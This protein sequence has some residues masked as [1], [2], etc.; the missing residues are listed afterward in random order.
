MSVFT[1]WERFTGGPLGVYSVVAGKVAELKG[2]YQDRN[3]VCEGFR[4]KYGWAVKRG[5]LRILNKLLFT[6][7]HGRCTMNSKQKRIGLT[8]LCGLTLLGGG[9]NNA[10]QGAFSGAAL[11]SLAGMGLGSLSGN[12]GEG[13]A[14]GAIVG[15]LF[16]GLQGDQN[17]R[18]AYYNSGY[19]YNPGYTPYGGGYGGGYSNGPEVRVYYT[20][21]YPRYTRRHRRHGPH[22]RWD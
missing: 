8:A 3:G 7:I 6:N 12:M 21:S 4:A 16:G 15:G 11:G 20:E 10:G 19:G 18:S 14:A 2:P 17:A 5:G 9:C 13:A 22:G 1:S